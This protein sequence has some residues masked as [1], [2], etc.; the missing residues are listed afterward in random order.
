MSILVQER[1]EE[2]ETPAKI[3]D[4][5]L[6]GFLKG[7]N[8]VLIE[9]DPTDDAQEIFAS[10]N[11]LGKPLSPFDIIR[12]DVFHRAQKANEDSE[13]LFGEKWQQFEQP[14]WTQQVRQG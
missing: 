2:G 5:L 10:L 12:N 13:A 11:G 8:V 1:K 4:E 14:F 9:L 7:F 6:D 3:L